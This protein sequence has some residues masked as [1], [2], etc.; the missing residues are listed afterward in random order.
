MKVVLAADLSTVSI[1]TNRVQRQSEESFVAPE[2]DFTTTGIRDRNKRI[3]VQ[4]CRSNFEFYECWIELGKLT[5]KGRGAYLFWRSS[6][7]YM[8][9]LETRACFLNQR[10]R[11]RLWSS[12]SSCSDRHPIGLPV[13]IVVHGVAMQVTGR[14]ELRCRWR[15]EWRWCRC[16][17][18]KWFLSPKTSISNAEDVDFNFRR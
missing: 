8:E 9:V 4:N 17:R 14:M 12:P 10:C 16:H 1:Q 6:G 7:L 3:E 15:G 5:L 2:F 11:L 18:L 13:M